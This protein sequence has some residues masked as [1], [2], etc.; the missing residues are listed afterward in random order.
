M[1]TTEAYRVEAASRPKGRKSKR[2]A[3]SRETAAASSGLGIVSDEP[4]ERLPL[5]EIDVLPGNPEPDPRVVAQIV[6]HG[7]DEPA[8]VLLPGQLVCPPGVELSYDESRYLLLA[9]ATRLAAARAAGWPWLEVRIRRQPITLD[10][11]IAFALRS[12][13]GRRVVTTAEK[14][15]RVKQLADCGRTDQEIAGL[16]DLDR[17]EV[18]QLRRFG[19]LPAAWRDRVRSYELGEDDGISWSA[20]KALIPYVA[21][22]AVLDDLESSFSKDEFLRAEMLTRDGFREAIQDAASRTTRPVE[23]GARVNYKG[24]HYWTDR[25]LPAKSLSP[26]DLDTLKIVEL[27]LGPNGKM[28]RRAT[29]D[30]TA[31]EI[32]FPI[33]KAKSQSGSVGKLDNMGDGRP[34]GNGNNMKPVET[35][36][37][38]RAKAKADDQYLADRIQRP[39]GLAAWAL[40]IACAHSDRL[41]A[42]SA[43]ARQVWRLLSACARDKDSTWHLDPAQWICYAAQIWAHRAGVKLPPLKPRANTW[44]RLL[45]E[46]WVG[47]LLALGQADDPLTAHDDIELTACELILWPQTDM[48]IAPGLFEPDEFPPAPEPWID[49][50]LLQ[51]IAA[52]LQASLA[53]TWE[54]ARRK[55][56]GAPLGFALQATAWLTCFLN[57]HDKRQLVTLTGSD[58][59]RSWGPIA[60]AGLGSTAVEFAKRSKSQMVEGLIAAH[61]AEGLRLPKSLAVAKPK[62]GPPRRS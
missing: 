3:V 37:D 16:L 53:D 51:P 56:S 59:L 62:K 29:C 11:A 61:V 34:N 42:G 28:E 15:A 57:A 55:A 5:G 1:E 43:Q 20:A 36:L 24:D 19:E 13:T 60:A 32:V 9:G 54:A 41:R 4:I 48:L 25:K 46:D 7:Q 31:F 17:P 40:R 38:R 50:W 23:P 12:N 14:A 27:P 30:E 47:S 58:V 52:E 44:D 22:P 45:K 18:N 2:A 39:G 6:E 35:E 33:P 26:E 49:D 21:V 8:I 10:D